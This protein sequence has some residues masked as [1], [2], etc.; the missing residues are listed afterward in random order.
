M[1]NQGNARRIIRCPLCQKGRLLDVAVRADLPKLVFYDP[2][3]AELSQMFL[4]CPKCGQQIG[5]SVKT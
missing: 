4:K 5:L 1:R 2:S 3:Q